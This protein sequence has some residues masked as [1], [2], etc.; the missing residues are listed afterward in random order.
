MCHD[1]HFDGMAPWQSKK[2]GNE[3]MKSST[4]AAQKEQRDKASSLVYG[5]VRFSSK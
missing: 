2:Q 3:K 1:Y 5:T 4:T